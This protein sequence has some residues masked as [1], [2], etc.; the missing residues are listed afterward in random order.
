MDKETWAR[1]QL[2]IMGN[3][4]PSD[5][6]VKIIIDTIDNDEWVKANYERSVKKNNSR[7]RRTLKPRIAK[8]K[9]NK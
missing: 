4:N 5:E 1:K 7:M 6:S 2:A 3:K 8:R 9:K